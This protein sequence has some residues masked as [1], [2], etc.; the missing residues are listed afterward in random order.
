MRYLLVAVLLLVALVPAAALGGSPPTHEI[1][2]A[3]SQWRVVE[4]DSGPD[5]YY[6]IVHDDSGAFIRAQ[7]RTPM[8]T[9]VL[10]FQVAD[11]VRPKAR[12]VRWRWRAMKLPVGGNECDKDRQD[13]AAVVY[14][15]WKR[16][17]RWY[18]LKYVWSSVAPKGQTC[19]RK[20]NPFAVQDTII[21]ETGGP[22]GTWM[23]EEID[24]KSEFRRHFED[25]R[26]DADVPD[27]IG[28]GIMSDGDAT[29]SESAADYADVA[30]SM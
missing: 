21:L 14:L 5:N 28:I 11:D 26:L 22:V 27:F 17:W 24:L 3:P 15:T 12:A 9:M 16:G 25:G 13:S 20:R 18:S 19:D 30:L 6:A 29:H 10:G 1:D 8:K 23:T 4:R 7:Y 2:V